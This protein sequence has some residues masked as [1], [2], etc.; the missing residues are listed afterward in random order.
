MAAAAIY[1]LAG[2]C[3]F[4]S[5]R[6]RTHSTPPQPQSR[7]PVRRR[8]MGHYRHEGTVP[9]NHHSPTRKATNFKK[10]FLT[11]FLPQKMVP[12]T[13]FAPPK[14]WFLTPFLPHDTFFAPIAAPRSETKHGPL[15]PRRNCAWKSP[16]THKEG[17]E[18][19]K[20]VPDTFFAPQKMVPDTFFAPR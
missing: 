5:D 19:Q 15:P 2:T 3:Q 9:G 14:K 6:C 10:W 7:L 8:N 17:H 4:F 13:F 11:P 12:D 16:L 18:F 1:R 20:M